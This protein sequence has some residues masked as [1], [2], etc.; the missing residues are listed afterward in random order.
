MEFIEVEN[1]FETFDKQIV[2]PSFSSINFKSLANK[3]PLTYRS[4]HQDTSTLPNSDPNSNHS[5]LALNIRMS[6]IQQ[7]KW[8]DHDQNYE[9]LP[10][11][12]TEFY[13]PMDKEIQTD[14]P[15]M[16]SQ[17]LLTFNKR[18]LTSLCSIIMR[19]N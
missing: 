8:G 10:S 15:T 11:Q 2:N 16:D 7:S 18:Q 4:I 19:E 9:E 14:N 3:L 5:K 17:E 6:G 1:L 13:V 12:I